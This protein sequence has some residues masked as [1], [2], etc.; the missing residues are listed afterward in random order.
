M[1]AGDSWGLDVATPL[2]F[3]VA[4]GKMFMSFLLCVGTI[5]N[6]VK[7][8][9]WLRRLQLVDVG[10]SGAKVGFGYSWIYC[11]LRRTPGMEYHSRPSV[12]KAT[13]VLCFTY[14]VIHEAIS[15]VWV[16]SSGFHED[17]KPIVDVK[18]KGEYLA[19]LS[20]LRLPSARRMY[21]LTQSL[22]PLLLTGT[23]AFHCHCLCN[24]RR[25]FLIAP[26]IVA[27]NFNAATAKLDGRDDLFIRHPFQ[28]SADWCGTSLPL[29]SPEAAVAM[30]RW[31]MGRWP[32][33]ILRRP[34]E[35]LLFDK[36]RISQN[37]ALRASEMLRR[38]AEREGA[39]G[40]AAQQCGINIRM[41]YLQ[42]ENNNGRSA[43]ETSN[44]ITM[45]NPKIVE[46]SAEEDLLVWNESCLVLPPTFTAT[47]LR[48]SMVRVRFQDCQG[49]TQERRF[50]NEAARALQ[51]EMD[52]DRGILV[53]D[54][55]DLCELENDTMRNIEAPGHS[56]RMKLA[57]QRYYG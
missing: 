53:T 23:F 22:L 17:P 47:V 5:T 40:L 41:I 48:D 20:I 37:L 44:G 57:Y 12:Q 21:G 31:E 50:E 32:D 1:A 26:P 54:H 24:S 7:G 27:L 38:T 25:A 14:L 43:G 29:L 49:R 11:W 30:D 10:E 6:Y 51:H 42:L 34:S 33:P 2:V 3:V 52:H 8:K 56:E 19:R 55:V 45:I 46:R 28:Y 13:Y 16:R 36:G 4:P 39:V 18:R 35:P 15:H 9:L